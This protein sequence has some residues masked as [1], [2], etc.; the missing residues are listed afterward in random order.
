[1][2]CVDKHASIYRQSNG[3][4]HH[5]SPTA[6]DLPIFSNDDGQREAEADDLLLVVWAECPDPS[7]RQLVDRG[8]LLVASATALAWTV[9]LLLS[10][11]FL[12]PT[13]RF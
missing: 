6:L 7:D 5:K 3:T 10:L 12:S 9:G 13:K 11:Y 2:N 1:M 8:H 4:N